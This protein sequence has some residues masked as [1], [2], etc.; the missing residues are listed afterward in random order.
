MGMR[1]KLR[2]KSRM[3]RIVTLTEERDALRASRDLCREERDTAKRLFMMLGDTAKARAEE[4][5]RLQAGIEKLSVQY[6]QTVDD[7]AGAEEEAAEAQG[8][9]K[10][11]RAQ[12]R[13]ASKE[14]RDLRYERDQL[15]DGLP[16]CARCEA[17]VE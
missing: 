5:E 2:E 11:L 7:L 6:E 9:I 17:E 4:I 13:T 12:L 16:V 3:A 15:R 10:E 8:Q 1:G 14:A